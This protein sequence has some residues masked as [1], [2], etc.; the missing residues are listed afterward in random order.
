MYVEY[1]NSGSFYVAPFESFSVDCDAPVL[2]LITR[3]GAVVPL[4]FA[5][6]ELAMEAFLLIYKALRDSLP[7][8]SIAPIQYKNGQSKNVK[9][10][11]KA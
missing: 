1:N 11:S 6:K 7:T 2:K 9:C 4:Q 8:V 3:N 10:R 5:R